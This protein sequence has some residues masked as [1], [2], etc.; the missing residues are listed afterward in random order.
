MLWQRLKE[1]IKRQN[2]LLWCVVYFPIA[3]N[4]SGSFLMEKKTDLDLLNVIELWFAFSF[5]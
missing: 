4:L 5:S 3:N 1:S 2:P